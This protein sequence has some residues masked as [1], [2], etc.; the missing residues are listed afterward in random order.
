VTLRAGKV[1]FK[2]NLVVGVWCWV[3]LAG[4]LV[5]VGVFAGG[6]RFEGPGVGLLIADF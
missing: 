5:F 2:G 4:L 1:D 6:F 3:A